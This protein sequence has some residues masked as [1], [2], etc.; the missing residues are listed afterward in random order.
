MSSS[1]AGFPCPPD[2]PPPVPSRLSLWP[3]QSR[4]PP[5]LTGELLPR[6]TPPYPLLIQ[7]QSS[8]SENSIPSVETVPQLVMSIRS[9]DD[10]APPLDPSSQ[11]NA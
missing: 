4:E 1:Q 10:V 9:R 7:P 2:H 6:P 8:A 3:R 5:P 11:K